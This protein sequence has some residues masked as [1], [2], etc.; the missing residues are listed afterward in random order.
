MKRL[1]KQP[2]EMSRRE[3][4]LR[5]PVNKTATFSYHS[6]RSELPAN[7][8]RQPQQEENKTAA[9]RAVYSKSQ[10]FGVVLALIAIVLI[11]SILLNVS[12]SP[13]VVILS[14]AG[15]TSFL[16]NTT[17]YQRAA[18]KQFSASILNKNKITIDT[19]T[20]SHQLL[21]EFP[22]LSSVSITVPLFSNQAIVYVQPAQPAIIFAASN[23]AYVLDTQ[24]RA[25]QIASQFSN[26]ASLGLP[27]VTDQSAY[28]AKVGQQALNEGDVSFIQTVIYELAQRKLAISSFNLPAG[29]S[30]L[31]AV[32]AGEPY[33]VKFNLENSDARQQAGTFLAVRQQLVGEN[34]TPAHYIDVRVDGRAYYE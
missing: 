17:T 29:S 20:I 27:T 1:K 31:D 28:Q 34:I 30:E 23:G 12:S 5:E 4:L 11:A 33:Y 9:K 26:L 18:I 7:A 15:E 8:T 25:L 19:T 21:S 14:T 6:R 22:E 32:I 13:K 3:R 10:R 2:L 16:Q 24:G